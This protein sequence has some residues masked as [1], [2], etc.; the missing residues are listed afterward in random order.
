MAPGFGKMARTSLTSTGI[1]K[2]ESQHQTPIVQQGGASNGLIGS[3]SLTIVQVVGTTFA[4]Q[5]LYAVHK[6]RWARSYNNQAALGLMF[7]Q[8]LQKTQR[9][10]KQNYPALTSSSIRQKGRKRKWLSK[11]NKTQQRTT[12]TRLTCGLFILTFSRSSGS[13]RCPALGQRTPY[14][15]PASWPG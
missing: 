3:G 6:M 15:S 11:A 5:L 10:K 8:S 7:Q 14:W 2:L 12:S 13:R 1:P 4:L 9:A